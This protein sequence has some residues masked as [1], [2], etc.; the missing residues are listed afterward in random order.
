MLVNAAR[1]TEES[2]AGWVKVAAAFVMGVTTG[3]MRVGSVMVLS[4][5]GAAAMA[6]GVVV[7]FSMRAVRV[8]SSWRPERSLP[9]RKEV[10]VSMM[11]VWGV[12][13]RNVFDILE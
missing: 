2:A 6:G 7:A 3:T 9:L 13:A 12:S 4:M 10:G 11:A 8:G 5:V 1:T